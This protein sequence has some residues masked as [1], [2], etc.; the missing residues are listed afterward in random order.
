M[1]IK[2]NAKSIKILFI[3][4]ITLL[5]LP[6]I[7][8]MLTGNSISKVKANF[9]FLFQIYIDNILD[10]TI[11][12]TI[13][14]LISLMYVFILKNYKKIFK[15]KKDIYKFII[16]IAALFTIILPMTS[17]DV[18]YYIS[19]GWSE[20]NYGVNPYYTSVYELKQT[21]NITD[22]E[23]LNKIPKIWEDQKIVYGPVWPF[24][25]KILT[26][27]SFGSLPLA[28]INFKIFNC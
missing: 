21:N 17:T 8:Y 5:A 4:F 27:L 23:I 1:K 9:N 3:I 6:S 24:I 12:F 18:F 19:T 7:I 16:I 11:F 28:L 2:T 10:A 22:D 26:M 20:A 15:E 14:S 13:F 25:C